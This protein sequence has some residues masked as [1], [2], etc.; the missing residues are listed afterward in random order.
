MARNPRIAKERK[1]SEPAAEIR[2]ADSHA[3]GPHQNLPRPRL[4]RIGDINVLKVLWFFESN[5]FHGSCA[6]DG[7][8]EWMC[9]KMRSIEKVA[10]F[11]TGSCAADTARCPFSSQHL[12]TP[13]VCKRHT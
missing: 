9:D 8:N 12:S 4:A 5:G 3:M 11:V 6:C 13:G 2:A 7:L 10:H 1:F